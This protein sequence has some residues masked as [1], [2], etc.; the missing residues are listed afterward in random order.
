MEMLGTAERIVVMKE[1]T[2]IVT[3]NRNHDAVTARI[4]MIR[5]EVE[6]SDSQVHGGSVLV[7]LCRLSSGIPCFSRCFGSSDKFISVTLRPRV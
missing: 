7:F 1:Q 3:D 2:T 5:K 6:G 4:A